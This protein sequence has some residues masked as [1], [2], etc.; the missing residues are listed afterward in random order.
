MKQETFGIQLVYERIWVQRKH[1]TRSLINL[2]KLMNEGKKRGKLRVQLESRITTKHFSFWTPK[3][4][5]TYLTK[6]TWFSILIHRTVSFVLLKQMLEC[7]IYYPSVFKVRFQCL[8]ILRLDTTQTRTQKN[9][10]TLTLTP[11]HK[12]TWY[13]YIF[14]DFS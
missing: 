10:V 13:S 14:P 4:H 5:A 11:L 2:N 9:I 7:V 8:H 6:A 3:P 12:R 1:F